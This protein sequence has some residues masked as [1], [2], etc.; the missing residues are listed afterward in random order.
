MLS[1]RHS[2][3]AFLLG[4]A[5]ARAP[6]VRAEI[7]L[8]EPLCRKADSGFYDLA[9]AAALAKS[10]IRSAVGSAVGDA[11]ADVSFVSLAEGSGD[12]DAYWSKVAGDLGEELRQSVCRRYSAALSSRMGAEGYEAMQAV[13]WQTLGE[14]LWHS[15]EENRW[16]DIGQQ[17]RLSVRA[18]LLATA[19]HFLGFVAV[20]D[21][22]NAERLRPLLRLFAK[23]AVL[24]RRRE[25][26]QT[27]IAIVA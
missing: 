18:G 6:K 24:G 13:F 23:T 9:P 1:D 21:E 26:P 3:K 22:E 11:P 7:I 4:I 27:M 5:E 8:L 17:L 10:D 19:V 2:L 25:Q 14:P 12:R 15:F 16:D 20:G